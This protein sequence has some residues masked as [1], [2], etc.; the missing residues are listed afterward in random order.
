MMV[1][2]KSAIWMP[3]EPIVAGP[4]AWKKRLTSSSHFG[5]RNAVITPLRQVSPPT[6]STSRMPA[7]N[8]PG[9]GVARRRKEHRDGERRYHRQIEQNRR[10]G[11]RGEAGERVENAAV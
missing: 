4:S 5:Q 6:S 11:G 1:S 2:A 10:H 8:T 3:A 7:I 9:G